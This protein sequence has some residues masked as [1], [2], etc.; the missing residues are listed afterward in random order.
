[1]IG[2]VLLKEY[3]DEKLIQTIRNNRIILTTNLRNDE[4]SSLF[5]RL[6]IIRETKELIKIALDLGIKSPEINQTLRILGINII[7]T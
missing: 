4:A 5:G 6:A 3:T 2:G 7:E 1:L